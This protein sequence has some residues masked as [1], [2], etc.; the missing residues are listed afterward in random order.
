MWG[1]KE[2]YTGDFYDEI[3]EKKAAVKRNEA[4]A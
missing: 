4:L 1:N 3:E 2:H